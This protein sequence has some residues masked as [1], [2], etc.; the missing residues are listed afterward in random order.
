MP[1]IFNIL[2]YFTAFSQ[3]RV[4]AHL[5]SPQQFRSAIFWELA[6]KSRNDFESVQNAE[7]FLHFPPEL[8]A[9]HLIL[10]LKPHKFNNHPI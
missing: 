8:E 2:S 10:I 6:G 7:S 3:Y 5:F 4:H 9:L 1:S